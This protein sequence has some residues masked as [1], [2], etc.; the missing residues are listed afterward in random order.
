MSPNQ[1][2]YVE[3][4]TKEMKKALQIVLLFF[5]VTTIGQIPNDNP[6]KSYYTSKADFY[7]WTDEIKWNIVVD[8]REKKKISESW[9]EAYNR[10]ADSLSLAGGGVV[11]F[12]YL[13]LTRDQIED[14][15]YII[16]DNLSLR[17]NVVIR[18]DGSD[19]VSAKSEYFAPRT[20]LRFPKYFYDGD[21]EG[22]R[23]NGTRNETAFKEINLKDN[24]GINTGI[25]NMAINRSRIELNP[26]FDSIHSVVRGAD[27][28]TTFLPSTTVKNLI[29]MGVRSTNA[30]LPDKDVPTAS[31]DKFQRWSY[32]FAS[33]IQVYVAEN[34]V[35]ANNRLNDNTNNKFAPI[36]SDN[37]G[38]AGYKADNMAQ[39]GR[40]NGLNQNEAVFDYDAH[41]GIIVNRLKKISL[42]EVRGFVQ[43]AKPNEEP[44]LYAEGI[45]ILDNWVYKTMRVGIHAS[46]NKMLIKN[47]IITDNPNKITFL[48]P[49]GTSVQRNLVATYDIKGID[50]SG[51]GT[52]IEN[53]SIEV[54][55][56]SIR[57]ISK[58][59][60][61]DGILT[62]GTGGSA[63]IIKDITIRGNKVRSLPGEN[64]INGFERAAGL[65][66]ALV[67]FNDWGGAP[68]VVDANLDRIPL[69]RTLNNVIVRDNINLRGNN[70]WDALVVRGTLSGAENSYAYNNSASSDADGSLAGTAETNIIRSCQVSLNEPGQDKNINTNSGLTEGNA[71]TPVN[72][73]ECGSS[74]IDFISLDKDTLSIESGKLFEI[75]GKLTNHGCPDSTTLKIYIDGLIWTNP[76]DGKSTSNIP[77]EA[78]GTFSFNW[79]VPN[80]QDSGVY[81]IMAHV[82]QKS[83]G[84]ITH[85][86]YSSVKL[87]YV[88]KE[89]PPAFP[90]TEGYGASSGGINNVFSLDEI[91]FKVYPNPASDHLIV[92]LGNIITSEVNISITNMLGNEVYNSTQIPL[93][94]QFEKS[95]DVST[96]TAGPYILNVVNSKFKNTSIIM[97]KD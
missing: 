13:G 32:A 22:T 26:K 72:I 34:A 66:N 88:D 37:F 15:I 63:A 5:T 83:K 86:A 80:A 74:G 55:R 21:H 61:G 10:I 31:Q 89:I 58:S 82:T 9:L 60:D 19:T 7:H 17:N 52:V 40:P 51:W 76:V 27:T 3:L 23:P 44:G 54:Y 53:N 11:Y 90:F 59:E 14:S 33:N 41:Y 57:N 91:D 77:V 25:V 96:L 70:E 69:D 4:I 8:I 68:L 18:G 75:T 81:F 28:S 30:A 20:V 42:Y 48:R 45:E 46:G 92:T 67:E 36:N 79:E 1:E 29:V 24:S 50:F 84:G 73:T 12:P 39:I 87:I 62:K 71:C 94:N 56:L 78:D 65:D 38:Q 6:Y 95:I 16:E 43:L 64:R 35:V 47:N 85:Q 2:S 97:I 49:S 93:S